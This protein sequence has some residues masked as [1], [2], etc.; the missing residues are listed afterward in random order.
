MDKNNC[1]Y[2][3]AAVSSIKYHTESIYGDKFD[4]RICNVCQAYFLAPRPTEQMLKQAYD[5]TYYGEQDNKF[6]DGIVERTIDFFRKKRAKRLSSMLEPQS[7]VLDIGCGNGRFLNFLNTHRTFKIHGI[8]PG[9]GSARR[10][11]QIEDL[12][13]KKG[14]LSSDD[15]S[16]ASLDAITMFHVFEHL[17]NPAEVLDIIG[18]IL[19]PGGIL[20]ISFPNI[21]SWQAKLFKGKWLHLD[22][23]R[24]LFFFAPAEFI[25]LM[26]SKGFI[27]TLTNYW[28]VEQ[29]PFGAIQSIL[30]LFSKKRELLFES[31]KGNT[32]YIIG[33][34]P[35]L[36]FAHKAFF[37]LSFPF[38]ILCDIIACFF[39]AGAT[40]EFTFIYKPQKTTQ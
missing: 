2:C 22:P 38:F 4:I 6:G 40:V 16:P 12:H 39:K 23:P 10:A 8:E 32:K 13:L 28:S 11:A 19:K 27:N 5:K 24:H 17:T 35:A 29:N 15:F 9:E 14:F 31:L 37:V 7:R 21:N 34:S 26:K 3:G 18:K 36:I 25:K 30:N 20:I 33:T 1:G